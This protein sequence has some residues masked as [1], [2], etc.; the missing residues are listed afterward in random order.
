MAVRVAGW[1]EMAKAERWR[2]KHLPLQKWMA[3]PSQLMLRAWPCRSDKDTEV[4]RMTVVGPDGNRIPTLII[5][6]RGVSGVLPG[7]YIRASS[8]LLYAR[9]VNVSIGVFFRS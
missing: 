8:F 5:R 6:P 9:I 3:A 7:K 1:L 2:A 4:Q